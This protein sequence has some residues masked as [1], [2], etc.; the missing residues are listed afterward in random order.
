MS[1]EPSLDCETLR[2]NVKAQLGD[3]LF[4]SIRHKTKRYLGRFKRLGWRERLQLHLRH[5]NKDEAVDQVKA[6][7][8][9]TN[10]FKCS[11]IIQSDNQIIKVRNQSLTTFCQSRALHKYFFYDVKAIK[12]KIADT[13]LLRS[14][15]TIMYKDM[16]QE[17]TYMGFSLI[18]HV[19]IQAFKVRLWF[20][21]VSLRDIKYWNTNENCTFE[22][23]QREIKN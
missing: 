9:K 2:K 11:D 10:G 5:T 16:L 22:D 19:Y 8:P 6:N 17:Y 20:I 21:K 1:I 4:Q 14:L 23:E 18:I 12:I 13:L 15:Y 3:S 7:L